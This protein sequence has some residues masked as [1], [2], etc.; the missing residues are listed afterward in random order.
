MARGLHSYDCVQCRDMSPEVKNV[1]RQATAIEAGDLPSVT[2]GASKMPQQVIVVPFF[3]QL[4][5]QGYNSETGEN[6]GTALQVESVFE[7]SSADAQ[8]A[9]TQFE[10]VETQDSL[11][12]SL[13]ISASADVRVGLF[14]GGAKMS[15]AE[16]HAVNS[17]S[18]YIAGRSFVQNAV[19]HG[20]GFRH[21]KQKFCRCL[22]YWQ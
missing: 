12:E 13:G 18:S 19:R 2:A 4:I 14:S 10:S 15:F 9:S 11:K 21:G 20:K 8:I 6:V 22:P 1:G 17:T 5:G 16:Q 3:G 7:D